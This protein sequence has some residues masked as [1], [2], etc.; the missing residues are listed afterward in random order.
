MSVIEKD[1]VTVVPKY[2]FE[3]ALDLTR[4]LDSS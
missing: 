1:V 4:K 3:D 2:T